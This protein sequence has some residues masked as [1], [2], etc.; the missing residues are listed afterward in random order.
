[1]LARGDKTRVAF[2]LPATATCH[3]YEQSL[4]DDGDAAAVRAVPMMVMMMMMM[5]MMMVADAVRRRTAGV[6]RSRL[7]LGRGR[8]QPVTLVP[9]TP[10]YR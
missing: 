4:S 1:M 3:S 6:P 8:P 7:A 9:V 5:M 10:Q 2:Q